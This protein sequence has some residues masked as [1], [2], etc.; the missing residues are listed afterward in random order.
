[1]ADIL[2]VDME[3]F[4]DRAYSLSKVTTEDYLRDPRFEVIGVSVKR[5]GEKAKWFSGT[6]AQTKRFLDSF[7][8]SESVGVAHHAM[9]DMAVLNW[10]FDIRPKRIVDTLSMARAL[11]GPDAGNSLAKLAERWGLGAKGTEVSNA[12]G[13]RRLDFTPEELRRYGEYCD[14]DVELTYMLFERMMP[15]MPKLELGLIDLT[16]RM[17]SEPVLELDKDK[18]TKH[19]EDVRERKADLLNK[20]LVDKED[21]LSNNKLAELLRKCGVEPPTKISPITGKETY[22]FSKTDEGFTSLQEHPNPMVQAFVKARLGV[23]STIAE[24]RAQTFLGVAS[25]GTLPI[26]L[27]YYGAHTGRFAGMDYNIQNLPSRGD[28][29]IKQSIRAPSGY[30]IVDCDSSQIEARML[31]WLAGQDDLVDI[32]TKNNAEVAAGVPKAEMQHDPYKIM[33]AQIYRIAVED[34]TPAQRQVGKVVLLGAGYGLSWRKFID[35]ARVQG[36][37][38]DEAFAKLVIDTYRSTFSKVPDL[39]QRGDK[40]IEAMMRNQT[41]PLDTPGVLVVEGQR[42]RMPNGM[43]LNYPN[44]RKHRDEETGK[45]PV[46]YDAKRGRSIIRKNLW[47][48]SLA[49]NFTQGLARIVVCEQM[50]MISRR[51]KVA[52][53]VH[54]SVAAVVPEEVKDEARVFVE[55]CMR[56]TP[57]WCTGLP[58]G[59]ESKMGA[60]YG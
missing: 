47:G 38:A 19:L 48:G 27:K 15:L 3:T 5:N 31:A 14:N 22:A 53:T 26:P 54:D 4:Y 33:A 12:L 40:A 18:L 16:I 43:Y 59:C 41:V 57:R 24:T 42:I 50:L 20:A 29:S 34:V 10:H 11:G 2:V 21:L 51:Y 25:R 46:V 56:I 49:E 32:F 1:M 17:F 52:L 30:V 58:L 36:I 44:L 28:T 13:K 8:W 37:T 6:K 39:W 35:Y 9:F 45:T 60:T 55:S 23:K 7:N